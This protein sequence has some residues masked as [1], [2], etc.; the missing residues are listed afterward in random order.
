MS[1]KKQWAVIRIRYNE[2]RPLEGRLFI[3]QLKENV[4]ANALGLISLCLLFV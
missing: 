4:E 1:A 3:S 2:D